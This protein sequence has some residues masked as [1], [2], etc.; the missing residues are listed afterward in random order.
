[1]K[2]GIAQITTGQFAELAGSV[3]ACLPRQGFNVN[4]ILRIHQL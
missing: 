4:I 3:V 2:N 1:M